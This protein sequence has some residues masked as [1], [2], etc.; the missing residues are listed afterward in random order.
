[1][2]SVKYKSCSGQGHGH[3]PPQTLEPIAIGQGYP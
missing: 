3:H 1:M 2:L